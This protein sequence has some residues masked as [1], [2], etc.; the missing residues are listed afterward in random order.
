MYI[1]YNKYR[2]QTYFI[3][4]YNIVY[5]RQDGGW[6]L[7]APGGEQDPGGG[8]RGDRAGLRQQ[9]YRQ[10]S[11]FLHNSLKSMFFWGGYV[12]FFKIQNTKYNIEYQNQDIF[13][14]L[15]NLN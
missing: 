13:D 6:G 8:P 1:V 12:I 9:H 10:E 14:Y 11:A 5:F 3:S 15:V 2:I 4:S 7:D